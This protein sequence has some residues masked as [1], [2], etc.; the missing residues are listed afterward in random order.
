MSMS[1]SHGGNRRPSATKPGAK[2]GAPRSKRTPAK[3]DLVES[4]LADASADAEAASASA[5][6]AEAEAAEPEVAEETAPATP[7]RRTTTTPKARTAKTTP[8]KAASR[9]GAKAATGSRPA[10]KGGSRKPIAPVKVSQGRNWGPIA[11]F[12]AVALVAVGIIAFAGWQVHQS[13]RTF[14][15]RAED[16][17]GVVNYRKTDPALKQVAQHAWGPLKYPQSPPVGGRHNYNWQNCMGDVYDQP[18]AS[19]HAVHSLEH[20]AVWVTY[21][22]DRLSKDQVE[23]L[24][25]KVRG[26]E[27]M[28]MSPYSGLDKAISLQ[29]WGFQLKVD[30]VTDKRIDDFI[31]LMR[32]NGGIEKDAVCSGG[33]TETGTTPH[34]LGKDAPNPQNPPN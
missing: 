24:A 34:D 2:P 28:L 8:A 1:T 20:G 18:I 7:S 26:K 12:T 25:A 10:A 4:A 16:I 15:Q 11:L 31:N 17:S 30:S 32:K 21:N 9:T 29:A 3:E 27:Y 13:N 19:E 5:A 23:T 33:I 6:E 14:E 22:P